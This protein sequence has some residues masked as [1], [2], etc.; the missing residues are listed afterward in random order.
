MTILNKIGIRVCVVLLILLVHLSSGKLGLYAYSNIE[1]QFS[2]LPKEAR[3]FTGPLVW[4]HGDE[5]PAQLREILQKTV[6]GGNGCFTAESR[7]HNDWLG[8]GWYRDLSICLDEAKKFDLS[9]WIFDE[10]WWPSQLVGGQV[11]L[12]QGAKKLDVHIHNVEGPKVLKI[13]GFSGMKF[14]AALAGRA[15]GN[16][17]DGDSLIDLELNI[18]D[19]QLQ[20]DVPAGS[21]RILHFTWRYEAVRSNNKL[22]PVTVDGA[23]RESVKWFLD[24][25]YLPHYEH[26]KEEFGQTIKGYF[27]DEPKTK[28]DWGTEL[29]PEFKR[30]GLTGKRQ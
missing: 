20:W 7:P 29:I 12:E 26:F 17:I 28:G 6:E 14:V 9:M 25:V 3:Q 19:G 2:E 15:V 27:Y 8:P 13:D 4:L 21:W 11:P 16:K 18:K 10:L 24:Y 23:S 1:K 30:Q 5:S 22:G